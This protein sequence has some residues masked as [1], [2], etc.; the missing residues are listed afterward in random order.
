MAALR[1]MAMRARP[2]APQSLRSA[3]ARRSTHSPTATISPVSSSTGMNSTGAITP[4]SGWFQRKSAS[5]PHG[6]PL[7]RSIFGW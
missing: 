2:A 1:V 4:R 3:H 5:A 7:V 6:F